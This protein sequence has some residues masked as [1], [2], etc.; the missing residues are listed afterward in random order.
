[1]KFDLN[2][3]KERI[4]TLEEN[5]SF[6]QSKYTELLTYESKY[7]YNYETAILYNSKYDNINSM[8]EILRSFIFSF[9]K[10]LV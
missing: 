1:M 8:R 4:Q 5:L 6:C 7:E 10:L 3:L 9:H 2:G